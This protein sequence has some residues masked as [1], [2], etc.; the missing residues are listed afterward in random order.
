MDHKN[1]KFASIPQKLDS[2]ELSTHRDK[3]SYRK[4]YHGDPQAVIGCCN[5][6]IAQLH[7][8]IQLSQGDPELDN[9]SSQMWSE[10]AT[11]DINT[12]VVPVSLSR[13]TWTIFIDR[14][15]PCI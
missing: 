11:A 3:W 13:T 14:P 15:L 12:A 1:A 5:V 8:R 2:D 9:G 10:E 4:D 6:K 7:L